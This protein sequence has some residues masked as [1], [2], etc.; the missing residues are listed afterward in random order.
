MTESRRDQILAAQAASEAC[1]CP[2]ADAL[3]QYHGESLDPEVSAFIKQHVAA[4]D[5]CAAALS[6]LAA[7]PVAGEPAL[8]MDVEARSETLLRAVATPRRRTVILVWPRLLQAAAGIVFVVALGVVGHRL[9]VTPPAE[10]DLGELRGRAALELIEPAGRV[11]APPRELRWVAHP[12]AAAYRVTV[13]D[14]KLAT[15]WSADTAD[16]RPAIVLDKAA[17]D[18]LQGRGRFV[19]QVSAL[20]QIGATIGHSTAVSVE[21]SAGPTT[22]R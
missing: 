19:W 7:A 20:D 2:A 5:A 12:L 13:Y 16:A 10:T 22:N 6:F 9:F 3:Q 14:E 4:C 17:Q 15:L 1:G 11:A 18:A 8:P 21:V